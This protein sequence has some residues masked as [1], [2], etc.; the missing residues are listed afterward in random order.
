MMDNKEYRYRKHI[1]W[2]QYA[3]PIF[4]AVLTVGL[5]VTLLILISVTNRDFDA[6][7]IVLPVLLIV[8]FIEGGF[9]WLLFYRMAGVSVS[10]GEDAVI[11]RNRKGVITIPFE[12]ITNLQFP[13]VKYAGGWVKIVSAR[14]TIR[15]TVVIQDIGDLLVELR[16]A[17]DR[18]GL[19]D[20]YNRKKMFS[21]LKTAVYSDQS[22]ER[23]YKIFWKFVLAVVLCGV[24]G[25]LCGYFS[26]V[27]LV[28]TLLWSIVASFW[29]VAIFLYMEIVLGR[30]FAKATD[31]ETFSCPPRADAEEMAAYRKAGIIGIAVFAIASAIALLIA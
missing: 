5:V 13:S 26:R 31:E 21:F 30:R 8:F 3:V 28:K 4:F 6:L 7:C 24:V 25:G 23:L 17:L 22:W 18:K 15:L 11:Y 16:E 9:V 2:G 10:L 12:D 29:P 20:S 19:S 1:R 14:E 27:G